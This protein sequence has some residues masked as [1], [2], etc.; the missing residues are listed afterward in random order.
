MRERATYP[1]LEARPHPW[2]KQ[3]FIK[4]RNMTVW[5][6][7]SKMWASERTPKEAAAGF[8]LPAE[9]VYEASGV[10]R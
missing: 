9:A 7:L 5:Q 2:R 8:G 6:L 4:G 10:V 1:Y 3:L